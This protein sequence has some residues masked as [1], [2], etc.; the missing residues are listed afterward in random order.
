MQIVGNYVKS[1][2]ECAYMVNDEIW[3]T[4]YFASYCW[5]LPMSPK[6]NEFTGNEQR[7]DDGQFLHNLGKLT[8]LLINVYRKETMAAKNINSATFLRLL[9]FV[10]NKE[11]FGIVYRAQIAGCIY[12]CHRKIL[13][14]IYDSDTIR[15]EINVYPLQMGY[16]FTLSKSEWQVGKIKNIKF[17]LAENCPE[18]Q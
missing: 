18:T 10:H 5:K 15:G 2:P 3:Q 11:L 12:G 4:P 9:V 1:R 13:T 8:R 16:F 6:F 14:S 17:Q 7:T